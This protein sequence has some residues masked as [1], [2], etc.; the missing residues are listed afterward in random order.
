MNLLGLQG[1]LRDMGILISFSGRFSQ[2]IIVELGD[3]IKNHM[4]AEQTPKNNIYNVFSIFIEQTQN[5]KNYCASKEGSV[6][7]DKIVSSGIV[8]IGKT[9]SGYMIWSGNLIEN[10]D[11]DVL[12]EKLEKIIVL[13]KD[14]LK[15]AYKEQLKK[16]IPPDSQGA[17]IGLIDIARKASF[18]LEYYFEKLDEEFSFY[19][20][21]VMV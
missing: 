15:K 16:D 3:A 13:D 11:V 1:K 18:T 17:G 14:G 10:A 7:Y 6:H 4:E 12:R 21:K 9:D 19:E 8:S 20:L 5:I 2:G